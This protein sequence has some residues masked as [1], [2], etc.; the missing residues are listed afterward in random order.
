MSFKVHQIP[1]WQDNYIYLLQEKTQNKTAVIDPGA[2]EPIHQFLKQHQ[3]KLD[4]ILNTHH[5]WDHTGGNLELKN[6]WD[7]KIY[8]FKGDKH[9]IPGI[10][11]LLNQGDTVFV[12]ALEFKVLLTP[13]HTL[14][15]IAFYN[16]KHKLLFCGDTLF[17]AGC[18]RL[19]EGTATQ[20]FNSLRQIK[21]LPKETLIYCAHEYTLKNLQ[22]A[23]SLKP[24]SKEL[25]KRLKKTQTLREQNKP[26]VPFY[27]KEDLLCNPFLTAPTVED[28]AKIRK[29]KDNF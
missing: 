5:H 27:L 23:L 1:L 15:H 8:G 6:N 28:F 21:T 13:G 29:L 2:G 9:R 22:F 17:A 7:C 14:G 3:L 11:V 12:G 25:K 19:F 4:F 24:H 10:D 18:G 26:T 16:K 20:M